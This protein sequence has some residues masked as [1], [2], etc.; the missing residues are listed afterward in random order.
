[1]CII[2]QWAHL[3]F[4]NDATQSC[5]WCFSNELPGERRAEAAH[6][7]WRAGKQ[8]GTIAPSK[9]GKSEN[10]RK[11]CPSRFP[12][13]LSRCLLCFC[14]SPLCFSLRCI[15]LD[16]D[17]QQIPAWFE[18]M[19][20]FEGAHLCM[21]VFFPFFFLSEKR[22]SCR[23]RG[24]GGSAWPFTGWLSAPVGER[25]K[26]PGSY[27]HTCLNLFLCFRCDGSLLRFFFLFENYPYIVS[28]LPGVL[29]VFE[30]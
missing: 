18:G 30:G 1:M 17:W 9:R 11:H 4:V 22:E 23:R 15:K 6:S 19:F 20:S 5:R 25:K 21:H 12:S 8:A 27:I 10:K 13:K 2:S 24:R 16:Q 28:T 26:V 3:T 29:L 14:F 7:S